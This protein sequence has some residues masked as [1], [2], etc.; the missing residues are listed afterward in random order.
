MP[1][2]PLPSP[3]ITPYLYYEDV[4]AALDFLSRAF[5]FVEREAETM[6]RPDGRVLHSAMDYEDGVVMMGMPTDYESPKRH[7]KV[8]HQLYVLVPDVDAHCA[9]AR[10]AGAVIESDLEDAFYG[11]RRYTASDPEGQQWTFAQRMREI[12]PEEWKPSDEDLAGHG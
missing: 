3:R 9:R 2:D 6:R 5:G 11:D 7:G 8:S 4:A 10:A 1:D 12:P